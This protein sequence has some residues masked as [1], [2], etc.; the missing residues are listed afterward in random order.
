LSNDRRISR[1]YLWRIAGGIGRLSESLERRTDAESSEHQDAL[2]GLC[3][4][5]GALAMGIFAV[6]H[7]IV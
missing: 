2:I 7:W 5:N 4:T 3:S 6:S 1:H